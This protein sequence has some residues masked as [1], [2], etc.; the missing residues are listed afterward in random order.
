MIS[1][2]EGNSRDPLNSSSNN[3][4][5]ICMNWGMS[6]F[7]FSYNIENDYIHI[8]DRGVRLFCSDSRKKSDFLK[9]GFIS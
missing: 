5:L 7:L 6:L 4:K 8:C 9:V 2:G 3:E 1:L